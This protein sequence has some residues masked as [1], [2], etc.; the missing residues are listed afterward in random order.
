MIFIV[1][2]STTSMPATQTENPSSLIIT[3]LPLS[4]AGSTSFLPSRCANSDTAGPFCNVSNTPCN[5]L[6]PCFNNGTCI[7]T[8]NTKYG[9]IC[10]CSSHFNGTECQL[11]H[12]LCRSDT[13]W[14]QG[15]IFCR[16]NRSSDSE[17]CLGT[18]QSKANQSFL[19]RCTNGWEGDH[20]ETQVNLCRNVQCSNGGV[21]RSLFLNYTCECL[22]RSYSG[23]YCEITGSARI[24]HER[25]SRSFAYIAIIAM[26]TLALLIVTLDVLKYA[27]GIDAA[28]EELERMQ[29]KKM[30][31]KLKQKT[32]IVAIR[33]LYVHR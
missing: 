12:R 17:L 26:F 9:Y 6:Q 19:C 11:D 15:A 29:Q 10:R 24:L 25:L 13:C 16:S 4:S 30:T 20:C 27:F 18:C 1:D 33:Y 5:V 28:K 21:C 8:N 32:V 2:E 23:R 3:G 14:N 7:D 31:K 22:D